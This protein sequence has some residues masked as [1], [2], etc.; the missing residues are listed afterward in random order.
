MPVFLIEFMKRCKAQIFKCRQLATKLFK[1]IRWATMQ[2]VP[3]RG[4]SFSTRTVIIVGALHSLWLRKKVE[5]TRRAL[6]GWLA[7]RENE[8]SEK[9][10]AEKSQVFNLSAATICTPTLAV[11]AGSN[12][13]VDQAQMEQCRRLTSCNQ[14]SKMR[15]SAAVDKYHLTSS[16]PPDKDLLG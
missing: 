11:I 4:R 10:W 14:K 1:I 15:G 6:G 13:S 5:T 16:V 7:V 8:I 2:W 9:I 12:F 3:P